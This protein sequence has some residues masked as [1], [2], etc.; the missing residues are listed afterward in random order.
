MTKSPI[1]NLLAAMAACPEC[2]AYDG[3]VMEEPSDEARRFAHCTSDECW[4][5]YDEEYLL[6]EAPG[7]PRKLRIS[8]VEPER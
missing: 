3:L 2:G 5:T 8:Y 1:K 6:P 7:A 4:K